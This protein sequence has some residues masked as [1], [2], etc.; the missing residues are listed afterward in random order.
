VSG[1]ED[2]EVAEAEEVEDAVAEAGAA[3]TTGAAAVTAEEDGTN[4][5]VP[6]AASCWLQTKQRPARTSGS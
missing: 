5:L 1:I 3:H 2:R 6:V 4:A